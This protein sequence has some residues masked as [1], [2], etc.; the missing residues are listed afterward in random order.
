MGESAKST[1]VVAKYQEDIAWTEQANVDEV[2]IV[3]KGVH[4]PNTG[5]ESSSYLWY[6]IEHYD[7]LDGVYFFVQGSP[8]VHVDIYQE[9]KNKY[10]DFRWFD[11]LTFECTMD[12]APYGVL[13]IS[14]FLKACRLDYDH[15]IL[16]Y[17]CS[18]QFMISS[19]RLQSKPKKYYEKILN[20]VES[21]PDGHQGPPKEQG[22]YGALLFERCV[23]IIFNSPK[24]TSPR[25]K[26]RFIGR[27][28]GIL[29]KAQKNETTEE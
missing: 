20:V 25:L 16:K 24:R 22:A 7:D 14:A 28:H 12:G 1:L 23:G 8:F 19:K 13:D 27:N 21:T 11:N 3:E 18:A 29:Q 10:G 17:R 6:I 15:P 4:Y 2:F 9:L 5:R 26:K